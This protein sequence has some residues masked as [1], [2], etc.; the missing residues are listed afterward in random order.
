MPKS[1]ID[2]QRNDDYLIIQKVLA[3]NNVPS[4]THQQIV[5]NAIHIA[6][7]TI[8]HLDNESLLQVTQL[9]KEIDK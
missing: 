6:A 1:I 4:A 5:N 8:R 2:I 3:V 9:S 7:E